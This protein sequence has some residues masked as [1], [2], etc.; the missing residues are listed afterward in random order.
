MLA[1]TIINAIQAVLHH[2]PLA[3]SSNEL[4]AKIDKVLGAIVHMYQIRVGS[5]NNADTMWLSMGKGKVA[6]GLS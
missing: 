1:S 6:C 3:S 5:Y 2:C 4:S